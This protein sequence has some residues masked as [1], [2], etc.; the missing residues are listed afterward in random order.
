MNG[1]A[2]K[3][4]REGFVHLPRN[5][6]VG[7]RFLVIDAQTAEQTFETVDVNLRACYT[8]GRLQRCDRRVQFHWASVMLVAGRLSG[9]LSLKAR[10]DCRGKLPNHH[11]R[12]LMGHHLMKRNTAQ[13]LFKYTNMESEDYVLEAFV[14]LTRICRM[15]RCQPISQLLK[16]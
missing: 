3:R 10:R 9:S 12:P 5:I 8:S 13:S 7:G 4:E 11:L 14:L 16:Q 15:Q 6:A 2:V 1:H